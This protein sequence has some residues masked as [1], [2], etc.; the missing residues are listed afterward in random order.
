MQETLKT[1]RIILIVAKNKCCP[2]TLLTEKCK[3]QYITHHTVLHDQSKSSKYATEHDHQAIAAPQGQ[4]C[5]STAVLGACCCCGS[6]TTK[7]SVYNASCSTSS[8]RREGCA[9]RG[10]GGGC[11]VDSGRILCTAGMLGSASTLA[12]CV[13]RASSYALVAIFCAN[14][15]WKSL[16]ELGGIGRQPIS[17]DTIVGEGGLYQD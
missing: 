8:S 13:S 15:I 17:A 14:E 2:E 9:C 10:R 5:L 1:P 7:A 16:G 3:T 4:D 6:C 11:S 12:S